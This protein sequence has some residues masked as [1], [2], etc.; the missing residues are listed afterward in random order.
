M[1]GCFAA[2]I[3]RYNGSDMNPNQQ[4]TPPQP[5]Q[6]PAPMPQMPMNMGQPEPFQPMQPPVRSNKRKILVIALIALLL[7]VV[8]P[9]IIFFFVYQKK[10]NQTAAPAV[11]AKPVAALADKKNLSESDVASLDKTNAFWAYFK[12]ASQQSVLTITKDYYWADTPTSTPTNRSIKRTGF[13]YSTKNI[14]QA[15]DVPGSGPSDWMRY[16]CYDGKE[17]V[18]TPTSSRGWREKNGDDVAF[19]CK[20]DRESSDI[21]DGVNAGGLTSE[22][23]DTMIGYLRGHEGLITVDKL[24]LTEH[25]GKQ[26]LQFD[27]TLHPTFMKKDS[28]YMG[29]QWWMWAFKETKLDPAT[30]PYGYVGAGGNGTKLT[31][32]VDPSTKLPAYSELITTPILDGEGKEK[33]GSRYFLSKTQY[34]FGSLPDVKTTSGQDPKL[35]W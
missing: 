21:N 16:R 9:G 12:N 3:S 34:A 1:V 17:F 15:V 2:A 6:Q 35:D 18:L 14:M 8:I 20:L 13:D 28:I 22:Q 4:F 5:P 30:H 33:P 10:S 31:Y 32:F 25:K 26:Y 23:A 24:A 11:D 27:V 7:L 19:Y 29:N